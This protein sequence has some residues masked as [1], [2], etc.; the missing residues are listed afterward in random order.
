MR[1]EDLNEWRGK[2][3]LFYPTEERKRERR[4]FFSRFH[5]YL[6]IL[7]WM[8]DGVSQ[9]ELFSLDIHSKVESLKEILIHYLLLLEDLYYSSSRVI[10]VGSEGIS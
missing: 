1:V 2:M 8:E 9:V 5:E 6:C 10:R 7:A 4:S 3:I